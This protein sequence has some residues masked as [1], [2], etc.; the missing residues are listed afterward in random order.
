MSTSDRLWRERGLR[1]AVLAGD[2]RAWRSW[3]EETYAPLSRY[4]LW[5]CGGLRDM[6][7]EVVQDVWL[8]AVR[9]ISRFDPA[10]GPF[11][12][13]LRGIAAHILRNHF[14]QRRRR[15]RNCSLDGAATAEA[16][17]DPEGRER[18]EEVA[19]ALSTLPDH[20]E[21]I[22]R[23]KYL[24]GR[25]V[26]EIAAERGETVKGVESLLTRA[27]QAFRDAYEARDQA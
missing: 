16:P 26:A 8:T 19:A 14:R 20:Y 5:R 15:G 12:A 24:D 23:A 7:D 22:L 11:P 9:R 10:T 6:A 17:G 4:V 13:W 2:E 18:A 3:Y 1:D 25:S 27:R 21:D